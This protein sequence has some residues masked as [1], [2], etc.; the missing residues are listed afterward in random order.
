MADHEQA[1]KEAGGQKKEAKK[2]VRK[3]VKKKAADL[4]PLPSFVQQR[5]H[6]YEEIK[7]QQAQ[8]QVESQA[9][10]VTLKD[11]K[12]IDAESNKTTPMDIAKSISQGLANN[13]VV[14][15]V[16]DKLCDVFRPLTQD[17]NLELFTFDSDEGRS[18]FWHSSA[19][20][21]G[22]A[23]ERRYEANLCVGPALSDGFYYDA[24]TDKVVSQDHY[25]EIKELVDTI[26]KEQQPF[27]RLVVS[28]NDALRIFEYNP[29]KAEI[30]KKIDEKDSV[31]IYKCGPF[32]DLCRGPHVPHTGRVKAFN[33]TKNASAYWMGKA[34]NPVLQRVYG[35]SFPDK[36]QLLEWEEFQREAA[37][38]DH[39]N[40]GKQQELFFF[41]PYS[42]GSC[43]FLPHG[44]RIYN[45]LIEFIRSEYRNR[46]F[47]EVVTPNIF[48]HQLWHTSG[49]LQNYK[50]NMF[51][52]D[53]EGQPFSLKP[54]NCP[55]HCLMFGHRVRSYRELP[56]RFAD[57]GVLHRNELSGALTGLTRVRR[58]QQDDAHIFSPP[59]LIKQEI[60]GCL[61]F[62]ENVYNIFGFEFSLDLSTRPE[63]FLGEIEVW[64]KA[65]KALEEALNEFGRPW[66]LNPGDG[67][68]YG[69]K[70]DIH[71][72]DALKRSH[73]CATIQLDF[74]LPQ[75]FDL[76]YQAG[77]EDGTI[78]R[79]VIIHRA[80]L[81][82]VER[83]MANLIEHTAGKWPFWLSPRQCIVL[84]VSEKFFAYA[85][86]VRQQIH[87]EGFYVDVDA[88]DK[89]LQKKIR[90]A[91]LAQYNYILVVGQE[92]Q[93]SKTVNIRTRDNV[94]HGSRPVSELIAEFHTLTAEKK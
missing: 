90:E 32:V 18:T 59:E 6:V 47:L 10:K 11:G 89:K 12:V 75:R 13:V 29:F 86:E 55:G 3:E 71:I 51:S 15:K 23:L 77:T 84:P 42:P 73:Q 40:I 38:R 81:G 8:Q 48:D 21:L 62:M 37:R 61:E 57:F 7:T 93:S 36:K 14:A 28:R 17:C 82:S 30:I 24:A 60:R 52:F 53:V 4:Y 74:Q 83:M 26:V 44:A 1:K 31:T 5:L 54:M 67:A 45:K 92:E 2:E 56:L 87:N 78:H 46:G 88:S 43:F 66:K 20:I 33:I 16:N 64:A 85:S 91:Q 63:K 79:P 9:I 94:V 25:P 22:Q 58:F 49:H 70:I 50:E 80:I 35:V 72:T 19:H 41:H 34:E 27:E 76:Q 69:P 65:E 68:F 39:R